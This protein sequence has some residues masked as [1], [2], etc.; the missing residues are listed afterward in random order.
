[1]AI[2]HTKK[3]EGRIPTSLPNTPTSPKS[4][5]GPVGKRTR[6]GVKMGARKRNSSKKKIRGLGN[7]LTGDT[8]GMLLRKREGCDVMPILFKRK[9]PKAKHPFL[10]RFHKD[11]PH[12]SSQIQTVK[13]PSSF[14]LPLF[15][16]SSSFVSDSR[17]QCHWV[18]SGV[19]SP[20]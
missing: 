9:R 15:S 5:V 11:R 19:S 16:N 17:R 2:S 13:N 20:S 18:P 3:R 6:K 1:M 8:K 10:S 14:V 4:Q 12:H 7:L